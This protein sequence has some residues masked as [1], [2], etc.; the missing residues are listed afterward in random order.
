[1]LGMGLDIGEDLKQPEQSKS[2]PMEKR[3]K[4]RLKENTYENIVI[5]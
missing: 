1:M 2:I 4:I 3:I 5:P